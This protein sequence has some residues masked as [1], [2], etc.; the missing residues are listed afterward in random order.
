MP[1]WGPIGPAPS[2]GGGGGSS[3]PSGALLP[4]RV[5]SLTNVALTGLQTIHGVTLNANDR[6]FLNGQN[7][8][9]EN[10]PWLA[11]SGAWTRPTDYASGSTQ[12]AG[13]DIRVSL[14]DT[15]IGGYLWTLWNTGPFIVDSDGTNWLQFT[16]P[17]RLTDLSSF[18][19]W[20]PLTEATN[21]TCVNHGSIAA[22]YQWA[23]TIGVGGTSFIRITDTASQTSR[24]GI[25]DGGGPGAG[26]SYMYAFTDG[27]TELGPQSSWGCIY[28]PSQWPVGGNGVIWQRRDTVGVHLEIAITPAGLPT[29][30][31]KTTGGT[32]TA[33][34]TIAMTIG[35]PY[36][37]CGELRSDGYLLGWIGGDVVAQSASGGTGIM[38]YTGGATPRYSMFNDS[39]APSVA[40][41]A[42]GAIYSPWHHDV[43]IYGG[44]LGAIS[45]RMKNLMPEFVA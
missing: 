29:F 44:T 36:A 37:L 21:I 42:D 13:I 2:S 1:P 30:T 19:I 39:V 28:T 4:A 17:S 6:V 14:E 3:G 41:S 43:F 8:P 33:T 25:A 31:A 27:A 10:G 24:G 12:L 18:K 22:A 11:Q 16:G 34:G 26:N 35:Q 38:D 45:Q 9:T 23:E 7:A 40:R 32:K 5:G 15:E 20:Y